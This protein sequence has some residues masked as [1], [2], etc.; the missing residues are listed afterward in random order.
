[1]QVYPNRSWNSKIKKPGRTYS[2]YLILYSI[3]YTGKCF[4]KIPLCVEPLRTVSRRLIVEAEAARFVAARFGATSFSGLNS[5]LPCRL[6]EKIR[7]NVCLTST[8]LRSKQ[9]V[10]YSYENVYVFRQCIFFIK[11]SLVQYEAP[12]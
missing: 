11:V 6:L 2:I 9:N 7:K 1:M 12:F 10:D 8:N 5:L 3:I 4:P